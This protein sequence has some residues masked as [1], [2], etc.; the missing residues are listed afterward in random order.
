MSFS[1]VNCSGKTARKG[2]LY[3]AKTGKGLRP[4]Y[5]PSAKVSKPRPLEVLLLVK[6]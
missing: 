4:G 1:Q 3:L 5:D 2:R 6:G